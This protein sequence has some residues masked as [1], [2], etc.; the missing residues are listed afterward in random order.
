MKP[1]IKFCTTIP[2]NINGKVIL[3]DGISIRTHMDYLK[4][5]YSELNFPNENCN[6]DAYL[7]WMRDLSWI[8]E[9]SITIVVENY[10]LFLQEDI[11]Y[12]EFF[13][14]D[15]VD[16]I[17]PFW[18][19]DAIEVF[20]NEPIKSVQLVLVVGENEL[21]PSKSIDS[22]YA[23]GRLGLTFSVSLPVLRKV[24]D[25]VCIANFIIAY[26]GDEFRN[27]IFR[28]PRAW[29]ESDIATGTIIHRNDCTN[30]EFSNTSYDKLYN[31]VDDNLPDISEEEFY[32]IIETFDKVRVKY[33]QTGIIDKEL[34]GKYFDGL[35]RITPDDFKQFFIDLN[36]IV[37]EQ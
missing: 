21:V 37:L 6:W 1:N 18:E 4:L 10:H 5:I 32:E 20:E 26:T 25:M 31:A 2:N 3:I 9:Q 28:R 35:L 22:D 36:S 8:N 13:I 14:A 11:R 23:E 19:H 15:F 24:D 7:D 34:Y 33:M 12:K 27:A 16:T 30:K 29:M 17:F